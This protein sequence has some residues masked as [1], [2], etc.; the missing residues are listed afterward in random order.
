MS[1]TSSDTIVEL[2]NKVRY[3]RTKE[4]SDKYGI[5]IGMPIVPKVDL[6]NASSSSLKS[7]DTTTPNSKGEIKAP[8]NSRTFSVNGQSYVVPQGTRLFKNSGKE[9]FRYALMADGEIKVITKNGVVGLAPTLQTKLKSILTNKTVLDN[10]SFEEM[11]FDNEVH[12]VDDLENYPAGTVL[13]SPDGSFSLTKTENGTWEDDQFGVELDESVVSSMLDNGELVESAKEDSDEKTSEDTE[14][15]AEE[16]VEAPKQ[17][18]TVEEAVNAPDEEAVEAPTVEDAPVEDAPADETPAEEPQTEETPTEETPAEE[19]PTEDAPAVE[20]AP[21]EETPAEDAVEA[22]SEEDTPA[23]EEV[24]PFEAVDEP[25]EDSEMPKEEDPSAMS[26]KHKKI[27]QQTFAP[28]VLKK[29]DLD[30]LLDLNDGKYLKTIDNSWRKL[31]QQELLSSEEMS[32]K[33]LD[34]DFYGLPFNSPAWSLSNKFEG[35]LS[36]VKTGQIVAWVDKGKNSTSTAMR[37]PEGWMEDNGNIQYSTAFIPTDTNLYAFN[38]DP[39]EAKNAAKDEANLNDLSSVNDITLEKMNKFPEGSTVKLK[40]G[41]VLKKNDNGKWMEKEQNVTDLLYMMD[42]ENAEYTKPPTKSSVPTVTKEWESPTKNP[43]S[44]PVGTVFAFSTSAKADGNAEAFKLLENGT[45]TNSL[46]L[47][48]QGGDLDALQTMFKVVPPEDV[49]KYFPSFVDAVKDTDTIAEGPTVAQAKEAITAMEAHSGFQI[50]YGLKALP[51]DHP[52]KEKDLQDTL[53]KNAKEKFPDLSPKPA[54]LAYLK[55]Q[56][57]LQEQDSEAPTDASEKSDA[58]KIQIGSATPEKLSVQGFNGGE[59]TYADIQEA[60]DILEAYKGKFF[61]NELTKKNNALSVLDPT[62]IVGFSKDKLETKTKY[63]DHLKG[64]LKDNQELKK[65]TSVSPVLNL[66]E[67]VLD[68]LNGLLSN[69]IEDVDIDNPYQIFDDSPVDT[70]LINE[71]GT[72]VYRKTGEG[73]KPLSDVY[74]FIN[75][76]NKHKL[77]DYSVMPENWS[78]QYV[79]ALNDA[80][81][82][83]KVIST[84]GPGYVKKDGQ[85]IEEDTGYPIHVSMLSADMT[86]FPDTHKLVLGEK[87]EKTEAGKYLSDNG[88]YELYVDDEG[89]GVLELT[90]SPDAGKSYGE[91]EISEIVKKHFSDD[92]EKKNSEKQ[93]S[94]ESSV[95]APE[96]EASAT[97][98]PEEKKTEEEEKQKAEAAPS[99]KAKPATKKSPVFKKSKSVDDIPEG[100]YVT[101][102]ATGAATMYE[103]SAGSVTS[104]T[105]TKK[106]GNNTV[107]KKISDHHDFLKNAPEGTVIG[108]KPGYQKY[109]KKDTYWESSTGAKFHTEF[110]YDV[111]APEG[112]E[113]FS[114]YFLYG[115]YIYSFPPTVTEPKPTVVLSAYNNGKLKDKYGN[116]VVPSGYTGTFSL[117]GYP[118][119]SD[120]SYLLSKKDSLEDV[121]LALYGLPNTK[122]DASTELHNFFLDSE[123]LSYKDAVHDLVKQYV[124]EGFVSDATDPVSGVESKKDSLGYTVNPIFE[125]SLKLRESNMTISD[126]NAFIKTVKETPEFGGSMGQ[127]MSKRSKDQKQDWATAFLLGKMDT[128][129]AL[130]EQAAKAVNAMVPNVGK[131]WGGP[132]GNG[133]VTWAALIDGQIPAGQPVDMKDVAT[134][135]FLTA[136]TGVIDNYL[137]KANIKNAEYLTLE[138]RRILA[139][140]HRSTHSIYNTTADRLTMT[141]LERKNSGAEKLSEVPVYDDNI[142]TPTKYDYKFESAKYPTDWGTYDDATTQYMEHLQNGTIKKDKFL[143]EAVEKYETENNIKFSEYSFSTYSASN[144]LTSIMDNAGKLAYEDSLIPIYEQKE[145]QTVKQGTHPIAEYGDQHGKSY[146]FK[147]RTESMKF[148]ADIEH[149]GNSL[150]KHWGFKSPT[151]SIETVEYN[152]TEMYGMMQSKIDSVGDLMGM[153][154]STLT[155]HQLADVATEHVLDWVLD[156]DDTKGDNILI[157]QNGRLSGID[158]GRTFRAYGSWKGLSGDGQM[159]SNAHT[160]YSDLF[161]SIRSGKIDQ[162]DVDFAYLEMQRKIKRIQKSDMSAMDSMIDDAMKHRTM[163][164]KVPYQIDGKTVSQDLAGLKLAVHDRISKMDQDFETLWSNVYKDAGFGDLPT[165]APVEG[166]NFSLTDA[167]HVTAV[168]NNDVYGKTSFVGSASESGIKDGH[169]LTWT[170]KDVDGNSL[171]TSRFTMT[172]TKSMDVAQVLNKKVS[173]ESGDSAGFSPHANVADPYGAAFINAAKTINHHAGDGEYN[174]IKIEVFRELVKDLEVDQKF[175]QS[176]WPESNEYGNAVLPSGRSIPM[177]GLPMYR[178]MVAHYLPYAEQLETAMKNQTKVTPHVTTFEQDFGL[179]SVDDLLATDTDTYKHLLGDQWLVTS[180][181][182]K[183]TQIKS[184]TADEITT[185]KQTASAIK[186]AQP[187]KTWKVT[188]SKASHTDAEYG[189]DGKK[190]T[191]KVGTGSNS[192]V[193]RGEDFKIRLETG[194]FIAI[195]DDNDGTP[196]ALRNQVH[197]YAVGKTEA[198]LIES[199]KRI[200]EVLSEIGIGMDTPPSDED[201][202]NTYW[203]QMANILGHHAAFTPE[204]TAIRDDVQEVFKKAGGFDKL[205]RLS[206]YYT[207]SEESLMW[208]ELFAKHLGEDKVSKVLEDKMYMPKF[209]H[210]NLKNPDDTTGAPYWERFDTDLSGILATGKVVSSSSSSSA[211]VKMKALT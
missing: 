79:D 210:G 132:S 141:A 190:Y 172:S 112:F 154:Y 147:P 128:V 202:Q 30:T 34:S 28:E 116:S 183:K 94:E 162:K 23:E 185:V 48:L 143:Q 54:V 9:D 168:M 92:Y 3:V 66:E 117:G 41:S 155:K 44:Y 165:S 175:L 71:S 10:S 20:D 102:S 115:A 109:T 195:R 93:D 24:D 35:S 82:G 83:S 199:Q 98:A 22:P 29:L 118:M 129:Y 124:P 42:F 59:F 17:E 96:G 32:E 25:E 156:N 52:F 164:Y 62:K 178:D 174:A 134:I 171:L 181:A 72:P 111:T 126:L 191:E 146:F 11:D 1:G 170:E 176:G 137:A 78:E 50:A 2:A 189:P 160:V 61:K 167:N 38:F 152:G 169:V 19:T 39:K 130:D 13:A 203:H 196:K 204:Y 131:H 161:A 187:K 188:R 211:T 90:D 186:D 69:N 113:K 65:D 198:E 60:V 103:I 125:A 88:L 208:Q 110:G 144:A 26:E 12:E 80:V 177:G 142:K 148:R 27:L 63:I 70:Y 105:D 101:H 135:N 207:P 67:D 95:D 84:K 194:E 123:F 205:D 179:Y 107:G 114:Q 81:D 68:T 139:R 193:S 53:K 31:Y 108:Q 56:T 33:L 173:E 122:E 206:K 149:L 106:V 43:S 87:P 136:P 85:W 150:G 8:S 58:P 75:E 16:A 184:L 47:H 15:P 192:A 89:E 158:K 209:D 200:N 97:D 18:E 73:W 99:T 104:T 151:S 7:D 49:A 157:S 77:L 6:P 180:K 121:N 119:S 21:A 201:L 163:A 64:L 120:T 100:T 127:H 55:E 51:D 37:V 138:E 166:L 74:P 57:G 36:D 86:Q 145:K 76:K 182:T 159:N 140:Y 46:G 14:A 153:D 91:E 40:D 133:N 197:T 4:G 5:P 45:A